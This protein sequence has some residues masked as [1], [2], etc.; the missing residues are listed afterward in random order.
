M[1]GMGF[2]K[3]LCER[4][5]LDN[6]GFQVKTTGFDGRQPR[7]RACDREGS[8][9]GRGGH[10]AERPVKGHLPKDNPKSG[11]GNPPIAAQKMSGTSASAEPVDPPKAHVERATRKSSAKNRELTS[12]GRDLKEGLSSFAAVIEKIEK[13][14]MELTVLLQRQRLEQDRHHAEMEVERTRLLMRSQ[15][16]LAKLICANTRKDCSENNHG[17]RCSKK[18]RWED[19]FDIT[20][21]RTKVGSKNVEETAVDDGQSDRLGIK[22]LDARYAGLKVP[23]PVFRDCKLQ[24]GDQEYRANGSVVGGQTSKGNESTSD[25]TESFKEDDYD[26]DDE[27]EGEEE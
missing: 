13:T 4:M 7:A 8:G 22:L 1:N 3:Q 10:V 26:D 17:H 12:L 24:S 16:D 18:G 20:S 9:E 23:F 21:C 6:T 15:L 2:E 25:G 19:V 11:M 27:E 14:K 5:D